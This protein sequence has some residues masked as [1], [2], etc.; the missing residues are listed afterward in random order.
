M[1]V[2][3]LKK[4]GLRL[5]Q[6]ATLSPGRWIFPHGLSLLRNPLLC[7]CD[8]AGPSQGLQLPLREVPRWTSSD[9]PLLGPRPPCKGV[10]VVLCYGLLCVFP[11]T[12]VERN[13]VWEWEADAP[14][15]VSSIDAVLLSVH[16]IQSYPS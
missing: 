14:F 8:H 7:L 13:H 6:L 11:Y 1:R 3:R 2:E 12:C 15:L 5:S 9:C 10:L 4:Q 16:T